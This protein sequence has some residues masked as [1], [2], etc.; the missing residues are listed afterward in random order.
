MSASGMGRWGSIGRAARLQV[1]VRLDDLFQAGGHYAHGAEGQ[2]WVLVHERPEIVAGDPQGGEVGH[3]DAIRGPRAPRD[4]GHLADRALGPP[5]GHQADALHHH[6]RLA[7]HQDIQAIAGGALFDKD[8]PGRDVDFL[9]DLRHLRQDRR[10]R[11]AEELYSAQK[12]HALVVWQHL[13]PF[14]ATGRAPL[15]FIILGRVKPG[16][17]A[18]IQ[19][20]Q[21][22][23]AKERRWPSGSR[24]YGGLWL[25][26][27]ARAAWAKRP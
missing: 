5:E 15:F 7:C 10:V 27:A 6:A 2:L 16:A 11:L 24:A 9:G 25:S 3:G 21:V 26:P 20:R 12:F 23:A 19:D 14:V 18:I 1:P 17:Y 4:E 22:C 13:Y 8:R